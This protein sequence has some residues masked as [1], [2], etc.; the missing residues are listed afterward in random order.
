MNYRN[1]D[2]IYRYRVAGGLRRMDKKPD[3]LLYCGEEYAIEDCDEISGVKVYF[4][5][6]VKNETPLNI[7]FSPI[8]RERGDY[9]EE[10]EKFNKGYE[11]EDP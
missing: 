11:E 8:W 2:K 10:K 4:T 3:A 1:Q 5:T 9:K 6:L 7:P